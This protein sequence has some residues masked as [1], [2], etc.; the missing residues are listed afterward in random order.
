MYLKCVFLSSKSHPMPK[1]GCDVGLELR[2]ALDRCLAGASCMVET[3][4]T[5]IT[6]PMQPSQPKLLALCLGLSSTQ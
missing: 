3:K 5:Y 6:G 1:Y 2:V 4:L